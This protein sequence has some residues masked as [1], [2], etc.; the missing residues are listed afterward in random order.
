ML[1]NKLKPQSYY[2]SN[3]SAVDNQAPQSSLTTEKPADS[4]NVMTVTDVARF[5]KFSTKKVYRLCKAGILPCRR[6][7]NGSYRFWKP[8]IEKWLKGELYE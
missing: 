7:G 5:L 4:E 6:D 3:I 1:K 2:F 8:E